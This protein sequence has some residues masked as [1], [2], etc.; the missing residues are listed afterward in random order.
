M[1]RISPPTD[2]RIVCFV[3]QLYIYKRCDNAWSLIF[4]NIF[5][6]KYKH[7]YCT[8]TVVHNK[9]FR[10]KF[11]CFADQLYIFQILIKNEQTFAVEHK[12]FYPIFSESFSSSSQVKI[13]VL[14]F[15][16]NF[17]LNGS[18]EHICKMCILLYLYCVFVNL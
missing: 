15:L 9:V 2:F 12:R 10:I 14:H 6:Q 7:L 4:L 17:T 13:S 18:V 8:D 11:L 3:D 5:L 16:I 1:L